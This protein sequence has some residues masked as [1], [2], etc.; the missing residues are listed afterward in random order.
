[1]CTV[2]FLPAADQIFLTS[3]RDEKHFRSDALAPE[4]HHSS[5]GKILYPKDR[6]AGGTWIALHENGHAIVFL[7][8]GFVGH[9]TKPPYRKSRGLILL[10]IA[11]SFAPVTVFEKIQLENIEPFT[12]IISDKNVLFECRWDGDQKHIAEKDPAIPHIW[13]SV[14]LYDEE[15]IQKRTGW[16]KAWLD[17]ASEHSQE[18]ILHFHEFTGD[19]DGHN[20][21][22]MNRG[23]AVY[24]VSI[25]SIAINDSGGMMYYHDLR[26]HKRYR[27]SLPFRQTS[28]VY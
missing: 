28:L 15:I 6:D 11:D 21:L 17:S 14:T 12:A 7:N 24:T 26:N 4:I 16:F 22:K 18:E 9:I 5:S 2:S 19:G 1:M 20:D 13:S 10:E 25:T 23:G 3:N 27:N 8:G